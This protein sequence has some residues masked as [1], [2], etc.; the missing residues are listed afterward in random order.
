[1][2]NLQESAQ[3]N[4]FLFSGCNFAPVRQIFKNCEFVDP[5]V[6]MWCVYYFHP[7]QS[8]LIKIYQHG[9]LQLARLAN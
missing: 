1:L 4:L 5:G 9:V 3:K 7:T 8:T 2:Q 6:K